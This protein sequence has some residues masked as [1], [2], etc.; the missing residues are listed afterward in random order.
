MRDTNVC[1]VNNNLED[2][3]ESIFPL[4]RRLRV[5]L[6]WSPGQRVPRGLRH[7]VRPRR[8]S[9]LPVRRRV[10]PLRPGEAD[11][12]G[13]RVLGRHFAPVQ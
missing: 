5:R 9:D 1:V 4:C 3:T 13:K 2:V 12:H 6:P 7:A 10:R 8:G 11:V